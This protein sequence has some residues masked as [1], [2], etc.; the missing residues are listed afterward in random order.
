MWEPHVHQSLRDRKGRCVHKTFLAKDKVMYLKATEGNYQESTYSVIITL[1][2]HIQIS[3]ESFLVLTHIM[4]QFPNLNFLGSYGRGVEFLL[5]LVSSLPLT[6]NNLHTT[7]A[8]LGVIHSETL[9]WY[10]LK[11]AQHRLNITCEFF[12]AVL[13]SLRP[14]IPPFIICVTLGK[15]YSISFHQSS[16]LWYRGNQSVYFIQLWYIKQI[17]L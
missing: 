16:N 9:Q 3:T 4:S 15:L 5:S 8:H 1:S 13:D 17:L 7:E 10:L 2:Y 14:N 6:Q 12:G 11:Q